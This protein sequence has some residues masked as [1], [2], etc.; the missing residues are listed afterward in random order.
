M[1]IFFSDMFLCFYCRCWITDNVVHWIV[2]IGYYVLV[3]LFTLTTFIVI[4]TQLF[5]HRRAKTGSALINRNGTSI[6]IVLGLCCILGIAWGFV[7][8]THGV[9]RI[10]AYYIFTVLSSFQ[11]IWNRCGQ[12]DEIRQV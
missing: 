9:L 6:I 4:S 8:F 1:F 10:P 2:N 5:C 3:F 12:K 7:F 11:G